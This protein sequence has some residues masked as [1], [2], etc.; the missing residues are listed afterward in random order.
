MFL[1]SSSACK[2]QG[3]DFSCVLFPQKLMELSLHP[4]LWQRKDWHLSKLLSQHSG[5]Q[6]GAVLFQPLQPYPPGPLV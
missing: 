2:A 6:A 3:F 1:M 5:V 4:G